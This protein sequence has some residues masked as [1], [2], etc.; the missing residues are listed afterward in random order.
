MQM[1]SRH[2]EDAARAEVANWEKDLDD[3]HRSNISL[4]GGLLACI[5]RWRG[6]SHIS[7]DKARVERC[8]HLLDALTRQ[9][10]TYREVR[11]GSGISSAD[12]R[13]GCS[14]DRRPDGMAAGYSGEVMAVDH[15]HPQLP[16]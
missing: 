16:G 10:P 12:S 13:V 14:Q 15:R 4:L 1:N 5:V 9:T 8:H 6:R 11:A 7:G 3:H 2:V